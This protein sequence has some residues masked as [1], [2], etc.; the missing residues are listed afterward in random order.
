MTARPLARVQAIDP[1]KPSTVGLGTT[2]AT[3][4]RSIQPDPNEE[5]I[6]K[7][8]G[9]M[10]DTMVAHPV[11][12]G[13]SAI[14]INVPVA[15]S[16]VSLS[17]EPAHDLYVLIN[18]SIVSETGKKDSKFESCM[19][20]PGFRG[21]VVNRTKVEVAYRDKKLNHIVRL[22]DGFLARAIR[23]EV[24]HCWGVMY[25]AKMGSGEVLHPTDLFDYPEPPN[26]PYTEK[27]I[28]TLTSGLGGE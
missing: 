21:S 26:T 3:I 6:A 28:S 17:R 5:F 8:L 13:L 14:Q 15:M 2:L 4:S 12:I 24:D 9:D 22:F 11:C 16:I 27:E 1:L 25:C 18:P 23:H 10:V 20:V 19:S 7:L